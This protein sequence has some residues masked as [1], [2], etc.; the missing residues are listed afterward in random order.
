MPESVQ[1][2]LSPG[3]PLDADLSV[4]EALRR[5]EEAGVTFGIVRNEQGQPIGLVTPEDLR[6]AAPETRLEALL[7]A[8]PQPIFVEPGVSLD[9]AVQA[10]AKDLVLTPQLSGAIV[11]ERGRVLGVLSRQELVRRASR[12]AL[13]NVVDRME[14]APVDLLYFVC[15]QDGER[16]LV[17]YYDPRNPPTCSQGHPMQPAE[18]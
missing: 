16:Q 3:I 15:P 18:D 7:S 10:L 5:L 14:G 6:Q 11:Q 13:R 12:L 1:E 17:A 2:H 8:M 4:A 9:H